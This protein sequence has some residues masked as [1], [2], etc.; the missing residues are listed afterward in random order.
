[1]RNQKQYRVVPPFE[2]PKY[3][4]NFFWALTKNS[5]PVKKNRSVVASGPR[6]NS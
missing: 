3:T 2:G 4:Q 1:M 5:G 6:Y